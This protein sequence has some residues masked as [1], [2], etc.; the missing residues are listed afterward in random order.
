[1]L[2]Q[3]GIR[4]EWTQCFSIILWQWWTCVCVRV[5]ACTQLTYT[6]ISV[7]FFNVLFYLI[8][9]F[10]TQINSVAT[11]T[12]MAWLSKYLFSLI[13]FL[14]IV[15][16]G[17]E[18]M[19]QK[20]PLPVYSRDS[21]YPEDP[22]CKKN[23]RPLLPNAL[24]AR[25]TASFYAGKWS[26]TTVAPASRKSAPPVIAMRVLVAGLLSPTLVHFMPTTLTMI[27]IKPSSTDTTIRARHVWMWTREKRGEERDKTWSRGCRS[28]EEMRKQK[29]KESFSPKTQIFL[30]MKV[31]TEGN[32]ALHAMQGWWETT[33]ICD[34][35]SLGRV[36]HCPTFPSRV[37]PE[38]TLWPNS[39]TVNDPSNLLRII[40]L[41]FCRL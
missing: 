17:Q 13:S 33:C 25:N 26:K 24:N 9:Q 6:E 16:W 28:G 12:P 14:G 15:V 29:R 11:T 41:W 2:S 7:I 22:Y 5:C 39:G 27:P 10:T 18:L 38:V 32:E 34:S 40:P 31:K 4:G 37:V 19:P 36:H 30:K 23:A 8:Y 20:W 1:M 35:R 3:W 21:N